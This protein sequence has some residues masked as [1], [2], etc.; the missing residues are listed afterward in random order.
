[1]DTD[2]HM[3]TPMIQSASGRS[4]A[5]ALRGLTVFLVGCVL[6]GCGYALQ[7]GG[8][9]LPPDVK[10]VWIPR[11]EN[12]TPEISLT[13]LMTES[14]RDRFERYGVVEITESM[15]EADAVLRARVLKVRRATGSVASNTDTDLQRD[16]SITI[17]AE[18][19]R[20]SGPVLWRNAN[21]IVTRTYGAQQSVVV[22]SSPEFAGGTLGA[23]DLNSLGNE[24]SRE[25]ARGQEE[26]AFASMS[27]ELAQLVYDG[28]VAPDF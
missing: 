23:S 7:G 18:L 5:R 4:W 27:E 1:M 21:L 9:V 28:A 10:R 17:G 6:A 14:L 11:V 26:E 22:T 19:R 13:E 15:G 8:S 12:S 25:I 2:G 3:G 16:L 20:V 24:G